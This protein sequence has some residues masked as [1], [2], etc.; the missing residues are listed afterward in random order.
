[1]SHRYATPTR[2]ILD[3]LRST[4]RYSNPLRAIDDLPRRRPLPGFS[5]TRIAAAMTA[6]EIQS[7]MD[8]RLLVLAATHEEGHA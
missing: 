2:P 3:E 6:H 7:E 1:M 5:P 4:H 8:A